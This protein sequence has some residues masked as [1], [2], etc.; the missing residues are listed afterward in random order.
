MLPP[1]V[2]HDAEQVLIEYLRTVLELGLQ[3]GVQVPNPRPGRFISVRRAGGVRGVVV[4][5]PRLDVFAWA[6]DDRAALDLLTAVRQH[7]AAMPGLRGG[8]RIT[9][10]HEFTGPIPAPDESGQPRWLYSVEIAI[11]GVRPS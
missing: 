8:V 10:V 1:L 4:D 5:R 6:A 7:L 3:V 2:F 11:R 9:E